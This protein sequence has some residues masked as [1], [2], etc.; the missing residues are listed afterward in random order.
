M[1]PSIFKKVPVVL[2]YAPI[3]LAAPFGEL[4]AVVPL[5]AV[6]N[7]VVVATLTGA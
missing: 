1:A 6:A 4:Y 3:P 2:I 7:V 5:V